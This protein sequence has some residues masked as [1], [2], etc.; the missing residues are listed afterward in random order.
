MRGKIGESLKDVRASPDLADVTTSSLDALRKYAEG[1]RAVDVERNAPRAIALLKEAIALDTAFAMAWRKLVVAYNVGGFSRA[2]VDS[3]SDRA[4]QFRDRLP[5]IERLSVVG[6]H[7]GWGSGRD[8]AK[9]AEAFEAL[10]AISPT[11]YHNLAVQYGSRRQYARA[12][13]LYRK[14]L[15]RNPILQSYTALI[16]AVALQGR[17]AEAESL[18]RA[19][20]TVFPRSAGYES[21]LAPFVYRR[22]QFDSV[23]LLA[24]QMRSSN[25]AQAKVQGGNLLATL[26]IIRGRL[27]AAEREIFEASAL[28]AARGAPTSAL[29]DSLASI[30]MDSWFREQHARAV[31]RLDATLT[32][33]PIRSRP[34]DER[35]YFGVATQ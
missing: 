1:V 30:W 6:I 5:E 22:G 35:P 33:I 9:A 28:E 18:A 13:S 7:Y 11:G 25:D 23:A 3:A 4:L 27:R 31:Q 2:L 20:P 10:S 8:R 17:L 29:E 26:D 19:M 15:A 16:A 24:R 12:E 32:R 21:M 14:N 34:M